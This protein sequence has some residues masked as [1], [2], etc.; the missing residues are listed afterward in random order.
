MRRIVAK[1]NQLMCVVPRVEKLRT[2]AVEMDVLTACGVHHGHP[3]FV[4]RTAE[5]RSHGVPEREGVLTEYSVSKSN[6]AIVIS[7][8]FRIAARVACTDSDVPR[9]CRTGPT[10][11]A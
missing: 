3:A 4:D 7:E 10:T 6:G 9:P 8:P 11:T 1:I 2:Q 5:R